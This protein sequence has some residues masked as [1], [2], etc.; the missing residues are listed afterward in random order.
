[1]LDSGAFICHLNCS[2]HMLLSLYRKCMGGG[3]KGGGGRRK[4]KKRAILGFRQ[5]V[6]RIKPSPQLGSVFPESRKNF[7]ELF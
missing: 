1:M 4:K 7:Q 3:G 5:D 6:L 2:C